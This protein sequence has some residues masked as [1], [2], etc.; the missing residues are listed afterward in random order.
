MLRLVNLIQEPKNF[1]TNL[2]DYL[3]TKVKGSIYVKREFI[4]QRVQQSN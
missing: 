1:I 2:G 4:Q 3:N